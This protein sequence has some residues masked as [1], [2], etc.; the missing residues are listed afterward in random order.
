M[1]QNDSDRSEKVIIQFAKFFEKEVEPYVTTV[2]TP[3]G[4]I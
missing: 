3:K 4:K 1:A 2:K